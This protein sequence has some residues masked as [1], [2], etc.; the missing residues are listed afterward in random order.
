MGWG[1]VVPAGY[2]GV[3]RICPTSLYGQAVCRLLGRQIRP[4]G[5]SLDCPCPFMQ[6]YGSFPVLPKNRG[7]ISFYQEKAKLTKAMWMNNESHLV[8]KNVITGPTSGLSL[9]R[10][11]SKRKASNI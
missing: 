5:L 3:R 9:I 1:W 6:L 8:S 11:P 10:P 7:A 4:R 2:Q